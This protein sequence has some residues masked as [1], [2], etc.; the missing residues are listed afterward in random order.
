MN[1]ERTHQGVLIVFEGIDGCGKSTQAKLFTDRLTREGLE[2]RFVREPGTTPIAE[3]VR[4]IL[5][6]ATTTA[7]SPET[8]LFL[9]LAARADLYRQ[10]VLPALAAGQIVV[11]DRCFWSTVAYQGAGL[12]WVRNDRASSASSPR[13]AASPTW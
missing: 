12:S 10:E 7:L 13:A 5:L 2:H 3:S 11:S 1:E 4:E 9:Y 6:H 8:E